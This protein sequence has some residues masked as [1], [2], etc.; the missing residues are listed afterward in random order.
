MRELSDVLLEVRDVGIRP[1]PEGGDAGDYRLRGAL[2]RETAGGRR[3]RFGWIGRKVTIGGF[4]VPGVV[5]GIVEPR[6]RRLE[7][8]WP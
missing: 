3:R 2:E 1:L 7:R 5:L 4:G 8:W 6:Q